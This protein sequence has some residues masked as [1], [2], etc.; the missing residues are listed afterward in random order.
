MKKCL[1]LCMLS[2]VVTSCYETTDWDDLI[3]SYP[4]SKISNVSVVAENMS[5][6]LY[7]EAENVNKDG[8]VTVYYGKSGDYVAGVA[9]SYSNSVVLN[10][11][12]YK[13]VSSDD[14]YKGTSTRA[15]VVSLED[16]YPGTK[17]HV[18]LEYKDNV[19]THILDSD[20]MTDSCRFIQQYAFYAP[21]IRLES[22]YDYYMVNNGFE[23]NKC[24][25]CNNSLIES[26]RHVIKS[27]YERKNFRNASIYN[28]YT[29]V[30]E[31]YYQ[32]QLIQT[33]K[34]TFKCGDGSIYY[35]RF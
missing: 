9:K 8:E 7:I 4:S 35:I 26:D 21:D 27:T 10:Y 34:K 17:Y 29:I 11:R 18:M 30:C 19:S 1:I 31:L 12:D 24:L 13:N 15:Y 25:Y 2:V 16:L 6:K 20:F 22:Y 33:K 3:S 32:G 14:D 5:A 23:V 28:T